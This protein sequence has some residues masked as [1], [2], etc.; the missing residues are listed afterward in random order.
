MEFLALIKENNLDNYEKVKVFF[1]NEY[2]L[3]FKEDESTHLEDLY[4]VTFD[5]TTNL[6]HKLVSNIIGTIL[7]KSSNE[8]VCT[9]YSLTYD[10]TTKNTKSKYPYDKDIDYSTAL[11]Y[12]Y[13]D[14]TLIRRFNYNGVWF[15]S[16]SKC[17]NAY[18]SFWLSITFG[19]MFEQ[20]LKEQNLSLDDLDVNYT[21]LYLLQ[22]PQ[23]RIVKKYNKPN[24]LFLGKKNNK[25]LS[26]TENEDLRLDL[27]FD[28]YEDVKNYVNKLS[29][30]DQS[31]IIKNCDDRIKIL[32]DGYIFVKNIRGNAN[33]ISKRYIEL[34]NN[35]D[36][37]KILKDYYQEYTPLF[38]GVENDILN[39]A[40]RIK[41]EYIN[42]YIYRNL[43]PSRYYHEKFDRT[44]KQLH[45]EYLRTKEKTTLDKVYTKIKT[46]PSHVIFWLLGY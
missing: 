32:G 12:Q 40:K 29:Y 39:L 25:D 24:I 44:L 42:R 9:S 19:D 46:L 33:S 6:N 8:I 34:I 31:L 5:N 18:K 30:D 45:A 37:K 11:Y 16:T 3:V 23:N 26:I 38:V 28:N 21:Y 4:L 2:N 20:T 10:D 27:K 1:K 17:I 22:H 35:E 15:N 36:E 41:A 13:N 14:G 7:T 43:N